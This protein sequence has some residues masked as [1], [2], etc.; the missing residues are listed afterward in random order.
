MANK[1]FK[2]FCRIDDYVESVDPDL[3]A[4][5]R[6][7]CADMT[8]RSTKG[9]P[10][11]T[12]LMPMDKAF[13][14]KLSKMAFSDKA[15][16]VVKA[17][18]M[19]NALIIKDV[20]K[21]GS[22][23]AAHKEDIPNSLM[24]P[25]HVE[26]TKITDKEI[27]FKSGAKAVLDE[28]FKDAS[29]KSNLAV[30][31]L[32]SGEIPITADKPASLKFVRK[33]KVMG[34]KG[35]KVGSYEMIDRISQSTRHKIA[36]IVENMFAAHLQ[37]GQLGADII[38]GFHQRF[39]SSVRNV[40]LEQI[41]SLVHYIRDSHAELYH[42]KVL[43]M[44]SLQAVD[45][46]FLL[47]PHRA[48]GDYLIPDHVIQDWW[49]TKQQINLLDVMKCISDDIDACK[50]GKYAS[51][52][53]LVLE[54][55][56]KER[57]RLDVVGMAMRSLPEMICTV[58]KKLEQENKIGEV[59][60]IYPDALAAF[61]K[62][63]P[64][65]KIAQDELRFVARIKFHE[66]FQ[67]FDMS[68]YSYLLNLIG[69]YLHRPSEQKLVLLNQN[70]AR[71]LIQPSNDLTTVKSF[72]QS[73]YFLYIALS[74]QKCLAFPYKNVASQP[75]VSSGSIW[76]IQKNVFAQHERLL[77]GFDASIDINKMSA[78]ERDQILALAAKIQQN[79]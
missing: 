56:N 64:C 79:A 15:E 32:V 38:G 46:Y 2:A 41:L 20:F 66:L 73:T 69:E 63:N 25:Q 21:K 23:W 48:E 39:G 58:Y 11:I 54:A 33:I 37:S 4:I 7:T 19:I 27:E 22:D 16:D 14:D 53:D 68:A 59:D 45:F 6:G 31:K 47:E 36:I 8:L 1:G 42:Q 40:F 70:T 18:D 49:A 72:V 74:K 34:E 51:S 24:P 67:Q 13:R 62:Q 43:P 26:I 78:A 61:Y 77:K 50:D 76:N 55:I 35:K 44:L 65:L 71:H 28:G 75:D 17:C 5:I 52:V 12:F 60:G 29:K 30:W 9:K 3:A 10:G 57:N